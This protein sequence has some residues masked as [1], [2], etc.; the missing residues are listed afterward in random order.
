MLRRKDGAGADQEPS[1][2]ERL[3]GGWRAGHDRLVVPQQWKM[4]IEHWI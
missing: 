4:V 3:R 2:R 1:D